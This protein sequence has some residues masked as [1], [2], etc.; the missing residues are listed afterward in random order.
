VLSLQFTH[1]RSFCLEKQ[2]AKAGSG[3]NVGLYCVTTTWQ[4][5]VKSSLHI[6]IAGILLHVT[7]ERRNLGMECS[8]TVIADSGK[9][10]LYT[11]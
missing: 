5:I 11:M 1:V 2:V 4:Q 10:V 7:V 9:P 8:K 3:F 6:M